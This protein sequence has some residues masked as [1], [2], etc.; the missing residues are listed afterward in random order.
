M[1]RTRRIPFVQS[2]ASAPVLAL[3]VAIIAIGIALPYTLLGRQLGMVE[4]PPVYFAWLA[5]TVAAYCVLTQVVKV[6]YMRRFARW[7]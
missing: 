7:L 4:L 1:I 3:T 5:A 2:A 6:M